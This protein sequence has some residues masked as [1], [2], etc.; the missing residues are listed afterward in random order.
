MISTPYHLTPH[1]PSGGSE[2]GLLSSP[3]I[4]VK[5]GERIS[6]DAARPGK[7]VGLA[8][9]RLPANKIYELGVE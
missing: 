5:M 7:N 2:R 6:Q 4:R 8:L 3:S 1:S 9:N